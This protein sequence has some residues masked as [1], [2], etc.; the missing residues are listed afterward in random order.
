MTK[1]ARR[2]TKFSVKEVK[3]PTIFGASLGGISLSAVMALVYLTFN[4][5]GEA[6]LSYAFAGLLA[7]IFSIA[8][9]V[10]SIL[11]INDQ[12]QR[13]GWGWFGCL[14][15]GLAAAS[16]AGILYLGML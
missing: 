2:K 1:G 4:R 7:S 13:H 14:T 15:N 8:G 9:L 6:T 3:L 10:L 5:G 16:M 11:C 12:Y